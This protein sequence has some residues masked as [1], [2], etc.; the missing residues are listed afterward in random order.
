MAEKFAKKLNEAGVTATVNHRRVKTIQIGDKE[1]WFRKGAREIA[2][3]IPLLVQR[4][5]LPFIFACVEDDDYEHAM[6]LIGEYEDLGQYVTDGDK[7]YV[8]KSAMNMWLSDLVA[9]LK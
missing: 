8:G 6:F 3:E 9:R 5:K 2:N 4:E 7:I 1:Y